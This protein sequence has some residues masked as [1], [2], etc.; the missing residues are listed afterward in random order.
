MEFI[1]IYHNMSLLGQ[2]SLCGLGVIILIGA[3]RIGLLGLILNIILSCIGGG[4][5]N[6]FGGGSFSGGGSSRDY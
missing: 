4:N 1:A 6:G 2:I 3:A 5:G